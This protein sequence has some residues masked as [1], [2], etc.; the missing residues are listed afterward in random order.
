MRIST[1]I[2]VVTTWIRWWSS[3]I[4]QLRL[5][6][7]RHWVTE[8]SQLKLS[9]KWT[10]VLTKQF[11]THTFLLIKQM[12]DEPT[13]IRIPWEYWTLHLWQAFLNAV[14]FLLKLFTPSISVKRRIKCPP[15]YRREIN[16]RVSERLASW[17]RTPGTW[18]FSR[19]ASEEGTLVLVPA[20]NQTLNI[21]V[22]N[23]NDLSSRNGALWAV[24]SPYSYGRQFG[25]KLH[26]AV[27]Y[28][29]AMY[30][31]CFSG[32]KSLSS[33]IMLFERKFPFQRKKV[34]EFWQTPLSL[35]FQ[36]LHVTV[37]CSIRNYR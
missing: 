8:E 5:E 11:E 25:A 16:T 18:S 36:T 19:R 24:I 31:G 4:S 1:Q 23:P 30:S 27:V 29:T 34:I 33:H 17:Q 15:Q 35:P 32:G 28:H 37:V 3:F 13:T 21:V 20:R 10:K 2:H 9:E 22:E 7:S 26:F 12:E 14:A 6:T